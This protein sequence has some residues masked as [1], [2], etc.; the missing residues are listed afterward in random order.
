MRCH[1]AERCLPRL[2]Y[3]C[4]ATPAAAAKLGQP[5]TCVTA[6]SPPRSNGAPW[7]MRAAGGG[8]RGQQQRPFLLQTMYKRARWVLLK[9][10]C[11][12]HLQGI[13][14][15]L[16]RLQPL[17]QLLKAGLRR[18]A[19][20]GLSVCQLL[21]GGRRG[22]VVRRSGQRGLIGAGEGG[23]RP[24]RGQRT[25]KRCPCRQAGGVAP[26]AA[27]SSAAQRSTCRLVMRR[28]SCSSIWLS[29]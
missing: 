16:L 12:A 15:A 21:G 22:G 6:P 11:G 19:L 4:A 5:G 9:T 25:C 18:R 1:A 20:L 17:G 10:S 26:H 7:C 24:G 2:S 23:H 3:G 8:D 28:R 14:V 29:S 27:H 13:Q